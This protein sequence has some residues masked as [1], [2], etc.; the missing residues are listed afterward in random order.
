[1]AAMAEESEESVL[2]LTKSW[3][4]VWELASLNLSALKWSTSELWARRMEALTLT[5][6]TSGITGEEYWIL[7][8]VTK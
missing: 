6:R 1:M 2:S 4:K 7:A 8:L 3:K 5:V